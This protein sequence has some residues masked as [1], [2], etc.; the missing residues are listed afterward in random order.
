VS[1]TN[2]FVGAWT[3]SEFAFRPHSCPLQWYNTCCL[4][5]SAVGR[6]LPQQPKLAHDTECHIPYV[7]CEE[8]ALTWCAHGPGEAGDIDHLVSALMLCENIAHGIHLRKSLPLQ[9]LFYL[10]QV[11]AACAAAGQECSLVHIT[12]SCCLV[13]APYR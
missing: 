7:S 3:C 5:T 8:T 10:A 1:S 12:F 2:A 9:Y 4:L 6:H 13:D 11:R